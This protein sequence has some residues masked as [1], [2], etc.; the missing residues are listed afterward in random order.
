[1]LC[2][3]GGVTYAMRSRR[4]YLL[5]YVIR[6]GLH[7]MLC[8]QEGLLIMLCDWGSRGLHIICD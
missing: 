8:D 2:D 3:Q 4:G 6:E 5:F 7:I 1:M